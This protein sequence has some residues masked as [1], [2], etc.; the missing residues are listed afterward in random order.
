MRKTQIQLPD[1]LYARA[2]HFAIEKEMSLAEVTRRSL[3]Q[4]LDR[5]PASGQ[6]TKEWS[7]PIVDGGGP[8]RIS[9]GK[10]KQIL[11]DE[12]SLRSLRH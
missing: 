3:E 6:G 10:L 7:L 5:Y 11:A 9:A 12:E 2:K 4:F 1:A 8:I